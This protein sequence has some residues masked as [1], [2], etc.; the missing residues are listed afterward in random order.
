[1][2]G[3]FLELA[4]NKETALIHNSRFVPLIDYRRLQAKELDIGERLRILE[5]S[6]GRFSSDLSSLLYLDQRS[7]LSC[8]LIRQ[9]KMSMAASVESRVPFLDYRI[10]EWSRLLPDGVKIRRFTNKWIVKK[11]AERWLPREIVYRNKVG[12]GVPLAPWLR[13]PRGMGR[14]LDLLGERRS[15]ERGYFDPQAVK[16][17]IE[18][19]RSGKADHSEVLWGLLNMELWHRRFIDPVSEKFFSGVNA[20][21]EDA[22]QKGSG[23]ENPVFRS[24]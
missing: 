1:M 11:M 5:D 24:Q 15:E 22:L 8:I 14:F 19:H 23:I 17:L 2:L 9:D 6:K 18:E 4:S 3:E 7:Y 16:G 20:V 21:V 12:F 13:N 10:V